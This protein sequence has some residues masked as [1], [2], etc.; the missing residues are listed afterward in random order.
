ML[1]NFKLN[2][3]IPALKTEITESLDGLKCSQMKILLPDLKPVS[4]NVPDKLIKTG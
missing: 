1:I 4:N 2:F 3:K